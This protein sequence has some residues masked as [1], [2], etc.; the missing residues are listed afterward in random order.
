MATAMLLRAFAI[1]RVGTGDGKPAR[2][3]FAFAMGPVGLEM[4]LA[5]RHP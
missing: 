2:E 4:K 5:L 1:E 3:R